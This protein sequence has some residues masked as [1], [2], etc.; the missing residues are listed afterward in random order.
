[1]RHVLANIATYAIA[2]MLIVG[3]ALFAW[4]RASQLALANETVM[5]AGFEPAPE[6]DFD[7]EALGEEVYASNCLTCHG[8][9]GAGWDQYPPLN[10]VWRIHQITGGREQLIDIHLYG[11]TSHRWG[12]PM[13]PMGHMPDVALAAVLNHL[14]TSFGNAPHVDPATLYHPAEIAARRGQRLTP[15]AVE[16]QGRRFRP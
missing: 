16:E 10:G 1:V 11:L 8:A 9:G 12:A 3:A 15:A 5:L 13:P 14:V 7:W 6:H 2:V 4:M